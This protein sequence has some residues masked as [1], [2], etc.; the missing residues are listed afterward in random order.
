MTQL[1]VISDKFKYVIFIIVLF[2][3]ELVVFFKL[4]NEN[5]IKHDLKNYEFKDFKCDHIEES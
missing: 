1:I 3:F 4:M 5:E 2:C